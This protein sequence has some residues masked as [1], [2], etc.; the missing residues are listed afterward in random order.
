MRLDPIE[1]AKQVVSKHF[2]D[3]QGAILAGS[4]IR[5]EATET[6]D[7][8]IVVFDDQLNFS[9]RESFIDFGWN[10]EAFAH[11]F[12]S[13]QSFF[14][15]DA[16]RAR[17]SMP[18]MVSEGL[19]LKD[20]GTGRIDAIKK[21]ARLIMEKGPEKWPEETITVKRY[22][23]TDALDDFKGCTNRGEEIFIANTLAE[24]ANEFYSRTNG[25]WLGVSKWVI[26]SLNHF[27]PQFTACFV[28]AFDTFYKTGEKSKIIQLVETVLEPY[29]GPLFTGFSLGKSEATA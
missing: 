11:N 15:G 5:G 24:L 12:T 20:D 1:A 4:V 14:I 29:G 27:D 7:L 25:Q 8:D 2:P 3:C 28:E 23:L 6:S 18:R 17:P 21:E 22:F 26:R 9:Y 19:I 16:E 10:I 13:Y